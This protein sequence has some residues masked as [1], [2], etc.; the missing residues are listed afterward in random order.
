MDGLAN[1][2]NAT[3]I[4]TLRTVALG[5]DELAVD[6]HLVDL[7]QTEAVVPQICLTQTPTMGQDLESIRIVNEDIRGHT[8]TIDGVRT[9][10]SSSFRISVSRS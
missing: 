9:K 5:V 6:A 10:C 8:Q 3:H 4:L 1:G 2:M 7:L